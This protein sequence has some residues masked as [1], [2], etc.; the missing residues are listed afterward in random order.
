MIHKDAVSV[1]MDVLKRMAPACERIAIAGS[2]RRHKACC[3]DVE[4]VF[5]PQMQRVQREQADLFS[6]ADKPRT[7]YRIQALIRDG[8]W[9]FDE[10]VKRNGPKYKRL[11]HRASSMTIELFRAWPENWGLQM[12]LRTGPA[13]F[14]HLLVTNWHFDGAMP[15]E[16]KMQ[17]GYLW[18]A[19]QMLQTPTETVFFEALDLPYWAPQERTAE[20]LKT[21]LNGG[22]YER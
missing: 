3:K 1:A 21:Y 14:N 17:D 15:P 8:F 5:V 7:D 6:Y 18:R 13:E 22:A 19:G 16:M 2:I 20:L 12:V 4:I 10:K 9:S 11:I